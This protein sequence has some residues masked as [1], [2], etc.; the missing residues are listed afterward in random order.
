MIDPRAIVDPGARIA[1]N[2]EIGPF[3]IIGPDVEIGEGAMIGPHEVVMPKS[4][5]PKRE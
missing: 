4:R 2:V 5:V 3:S 1:A